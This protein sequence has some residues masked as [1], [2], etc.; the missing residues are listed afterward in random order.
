MAHV[1]P[2]LCAFLAVLGAVN[3][4]TAVVRWDH[5]I[6]D[7]D[8]QSVACERSI[9]FRHC[10]LLV[11]IWL[12]MMGSGIACIQK[13]ESNS[14]KQMVLI[15]VFLGAITSVGIFYWPL[16]GG[17]LNA[18][19]AFFATHTATSSTKAITLPIQ[20]CVGTIVGPHTK[21]HSV[22][23]SFEMT[24]PMTSDTIDTKPLDVWIYLPSTYLEQRSRCNAYVDITRTTFN[25]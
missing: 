19:Q 14:T 9:Q 24:W 20:E 4:A 21:S 12:A 1:W 13:V 5:E 23:R 18:A 6:S 11:S 7:A 2:P 3:I 22:R 16:S 17:P 15:S 25:I 10:H 8:G